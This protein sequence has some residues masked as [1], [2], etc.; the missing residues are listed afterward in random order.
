MVPSTP[1]LFGSRIIFLLA[2]FAFLNP[3]VAQTPSL[4]SANYA[5]P[6]NYGI[7]LKGTGFASDAYVDVRAA[8]SYGAIIDQFSGSQIQRSVENG[9]NVLRFTVSNTTTRSTLNSPG[10]WLWVVNPSAGTY[11]GPVGVQRS[12]PTWPSG[13]S[14]TVSSY[15]VTLQGTEIAADATVDVRASSSGAII[16]SYSGAQIMRGCSG[17]KTTLTFTVTDATQRSYLE[18][19]GLYFWVVN[20]S[21]PAWAGPVYLK[22]TNS[23]PPLPSGNTYDA[24]APYLSRLQGVLGDGSLSWKTEPYYT[25]PTIQRTNVIWGSAVERH[26]IR[27]NCFDGN[28]YVWISSFGNYPITARKVLLTKNG[29]TK[30][31]TNICGSDG[32]VYAL[33]NVDSTPYRIQV[34][35]NTAPAPG[36]APDQKF[37]WDAKYRLVDSTNN[38]WQQ[39]SMKTRP[40]IRQEEAWWSQ[41]DSAAE[42]T[43]DR[44][45]WGEIGANGEPS[46]YSVYYNTYFEIAKGAGFMWKWGSLGG[47]ETFG[48]A[49]LKRTQSW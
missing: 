48:P 21:V 45:A 42:G 34:W 26:E 12:A 16:G 11:N 46:G 20:P 38:C 41:H 18:G 19:S 40:A 27:K 17:D 13:L 28:S 29:V 39:D 32:H 10:L 24:Y 33:Y 14:G 22:K 30:D 6:D 15:A 7:A 4:Q 5:C 31:L 9:A 23:E 43:W 3:A 47:R 37:Y 25:S 2:P 36:A 35:G 8:G 49:C 44:G 1:L